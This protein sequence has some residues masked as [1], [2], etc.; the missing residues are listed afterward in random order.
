MTQTDLEFSVLLVWP[1]KC[2]V[3]RRAKP[4]P[5]SDAHFHRAHF[6]PTPDFGDL[7]YSFVSQGWCKLDSFPLLLDADT[8]TC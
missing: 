7:V 3:Y 8:H 6:K 2:W 5:A 4:C 1:P